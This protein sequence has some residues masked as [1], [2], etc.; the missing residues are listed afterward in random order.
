MTDYLA[1]AQKA[2]ARYQS[3]VADAEPQAKTTPEPVPSEWIAERDLSPESVAEAFQRWVAESL[4][5]G[6]QQWRE[7]TLLSRFNLWLEAQDERPTTLPVLRQGLDL[8]KAFEERAA[9]MEYAGGLPRAEAERLAW[10]CVASQSLLDAPSPQ[11]RQAVPSYIKRCSSC[12]G[13]DWGPSGK[14][15]ADGCEVWHC[16]T[17]DKKER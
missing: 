7:G 11:R 5:E 8:L 14:H 1:I 3:Q 13:Q 4:G 16:I 6:W 15:T 17:F 9:M 10:D 2:L 12:G